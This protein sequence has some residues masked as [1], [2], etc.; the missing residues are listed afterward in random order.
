MGDE[1][2]TIDEAHIVSEVID[3]DAIIVNLA[4]GYYYS[5]DPSASEIWGW[6]QS[7]W[8]FGEIVTTIRDR[9]DCAGG[10]PE[11]A[12]RALIGSFIADALIA[13]RPDGRDAPQIERAATTAA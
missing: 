12:V 8:S 11:T 4:N 9:Y 13:S 7:G 1:R 5:L 6:L 3:G 10:D 2:Y